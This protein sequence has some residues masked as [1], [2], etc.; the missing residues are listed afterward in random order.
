MKQTVE[1]SSE[2]AS[3]TEELT[4]ARRGYG[5]LLDRQAAERREAEREIT[6]LEGRQSHLLSGTSEGDL[7]TARTLVEVTGSWAEFDEQVVREAIEDIVGGCPVMRSEYF[8][9]RVYEGHLHRERYRY[10]Y[11]PRHGRAVFRIGL[12]KGARDFIARWRK[13]PLGLDKG[14]DVTESVLRYLANLKE[15]GQP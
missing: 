7:H 15:A 6:E 13:V 8:C 10:G 14:E 9:R 11:G 4:E 12:T 3:V 1:T 5:E 2:L